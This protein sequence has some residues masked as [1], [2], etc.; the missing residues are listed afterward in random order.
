MQGRRRG[1]NSGLVFL[2]IQLF[3]IGLENIP[4]ATLT[5]LIVQILLHVVDPFEVWLGNICIG[6][7]II[8][9]FQYDIGGLSFLF[10]LISDALKRIS[11]VHVLPC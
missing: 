5:L 10:L 6:P 9:S 3:Q 1:G 8:Y 7:K 11:D 2:A 4:P